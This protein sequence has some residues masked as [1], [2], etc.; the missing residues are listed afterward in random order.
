MEQEIDQLISKNTARIVGILLI[1]G[2]AAGISSEVLISPILGAPDYL[3]KIST[4]R[5]G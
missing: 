5:I 3:I 2:T 1:I 4:V